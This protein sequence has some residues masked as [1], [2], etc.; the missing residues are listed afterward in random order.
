MSL[1]DGDLVR[2]HDEFPG[3]AR[4]E[5]QGLEW[6]AQAMPEG[7]ALVVPTR[8]GEGWLEEPR[9]T[10]TEVTAQAAEA[11]GRAL[12]VTHAAGAPAFGAAPPGW[13]GHTR[14]GRSD[15]R[16]RPNEV[17]AGA[18]RSWGVFY[19]EDRVGRYIGPSRD[20]GV[21]SAAQAGL[22]ERVCARLANGDFDSEQ[23]VLVREGAQT[24]GDKVAVARTHGDLWCGNV[25]WVPAPEVAEWAQGR[26]GQGP[27]VMVPAGGT[28]A[29]PGWVGVG[30]AVAGRDGT[31]GARTSWA[32]AASDS[33]SAGADTGERVWRRGE[34]VGVL[35]DPLAQ[36]AH[37]ET[38]L[39]ALGVF[40]QR[41]LERIVGAYNEVSPLAAG[42]RERVA[43]H[44][45]HLVMIHVHLFGGYAEQATAI[46]RQYV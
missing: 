2:K 20:R 15:I 23:P 32:A 19:A 7:G 43:L 17:E 38:D 22:L 39:A 34:V 26:A 3:S 25:L 35:I 28:K 30:R 18:P 40:G 24:R 27:Q 9:L 10:T 31:A 6:L 5:A 1:W 29:A 21:L 45:L 36:G 12:A 16:L 41:H 33:A 37:A 14:M 11:F 46:A 13:D 44:Q 42:W 4:L 8:T